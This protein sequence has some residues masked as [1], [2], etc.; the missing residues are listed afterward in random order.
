VLPCFEQ[1]VILPTCVSDGLAKVQANL[2]TILGGL[3]VHFDPGTQAAGMSFD[4][5]YLVDEQVAQQS[6]DVINE[7]NRT[8]I[9]NYQRFG[10][11][12]APVADVFQTNNSTINPFTQLPVNVTR[13]CVLTLMCTAKPDIHPNQLGYW[14][15]ATTF[16]AAFHRG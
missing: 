1:G 16:A 10:F 2:P 14:V 4:D 5:P 11:A 3:R 9:D 8:E 13:I 6:L 7:L 12:L 15:I